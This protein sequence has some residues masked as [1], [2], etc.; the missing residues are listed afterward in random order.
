M[1][2][3][4]IIEKEFHWDIK[5]YKKLVSTSKSNN[6]ALEELIKKLNKVVDFY[7][8][9]IRKNDYTLVP[10]DIVE[11]LGISR[12]FININILPNLNILYLPTI[13]EGSWLFKEIFYTK[14]NNTEKNNDKIKNLVESKILISKKDYIKYLNEN[15]DKQM[16]GNYFKG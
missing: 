5:H 7:L 14:L 3:L 11:D 9:N 1:K 13:K 6:K 8:R 4:E 12:H 15:I 16:Q 10:Q 2:Y